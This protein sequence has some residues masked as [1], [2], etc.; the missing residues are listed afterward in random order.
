MEELRGG[1]RAEESQLVE[2]RYYTPLE[3]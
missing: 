3:E 1:I 2:Q